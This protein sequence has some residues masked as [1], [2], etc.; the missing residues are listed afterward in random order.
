MV[1][2]TLKPCAKI[3]CS[4][5]SC[6][7][8]VFGPSN[9][10]SNATADITVGQAHSKGYHGP[11]GIK[12]FF[13][14]QQCAT[15]H[16]MPLDEGG[17]LPAWLLGLMFNGALVLSPWSTGFPVKTWCLDHRARSCEDRDTNA[18]FLLGFWAEGSAYGA[19][20]FLILS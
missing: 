13:S 17:L 11:P 12:L 19:Q 15:S 2:C 20:Q 9:K 14:T 1:N 4:F 16:W 5:L 8:W 3:N 6:F 7:C 18:H 10:E